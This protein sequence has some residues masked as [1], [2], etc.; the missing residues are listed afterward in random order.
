M[1][2]CAGKD[3][4]KGLPLVRQFT[5]DTSYDNGKKKGGGE[6]DSSQTPLGPQALHSVK[7]KIWWKTQE[8]T[9]K[10]KYS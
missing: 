6:V 9:R 3:E 2:Y 10:K 1:I 8:N 4:E 5:H 7:K